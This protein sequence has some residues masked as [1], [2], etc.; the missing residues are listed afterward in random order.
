M[1]FFAP[2]TAPPPALRSLN[3]FLHTQEKAST[4]EPQTLHSRSAAAHHLHAALRNMSGAGPTA[5][6]RV[7]PDGVA[8]IT[9]ANPPVNA[10]HPAG[11]LALSAACC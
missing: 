8:V 3:Y 6:Y 10:L 9:L 1:H 4:R 11:E 7:D 5:Q 2:Q